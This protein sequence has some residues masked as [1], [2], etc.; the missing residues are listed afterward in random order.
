MYLLLMYP[1]GAMPGLY[2]LSKC[3]KFGRWFLSRNELFELIE[4]RIIR[5]Q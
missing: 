5:M 3:R 2:T 4:Q 1:L